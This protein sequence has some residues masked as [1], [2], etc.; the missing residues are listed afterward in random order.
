MEPLLDDATGSEQC[1]SATVS[2]WQAA[3]NN[4]GSSIASCVQKDELLEIIEVINNE[5]VEQH[6]F[7]FDVQNLILSS[8]SGVVLQLISNCA[9]HNAFYTRR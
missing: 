6:A 3:L 2:A 1:I 5:L 8:F 7:F 4:S 9:K